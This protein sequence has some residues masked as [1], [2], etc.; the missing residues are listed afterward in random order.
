M[1]VVVCAVTG[2]EREV[3]DW[4]KARCAVEGEEVV[5]RERRRRQRWQIIVGDARGL[6]G[7]VG[8]KGSSGI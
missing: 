5:R 8:A 6:I 2:I 1:A 4:E 3:V 7:C